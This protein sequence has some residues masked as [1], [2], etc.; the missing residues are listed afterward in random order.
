MAGQAGYKALI[1]VGGTPVPVTDEACAMTSPKNY[2]VTDATRRAV[3][4][5]DS[6]TVK[7]DASP[8]DSSLYFIDYLFGIVILDGSVA[9]GVMT[10]D[11][12]YVPTVVAAGTNSFS[13]DLGGDVLDTTQFREST[14]PQHGFRTRINGLND[15]SASMESIDLT[16]KTFVNAKLARNAVM[17]EFDFDG[18]GTDLAR[19]WFIVETDNTSLEVAGLVGE[20]ISLQLEADDDAMALRSFSF[21]SE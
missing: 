9:D 17:V 18:T 8:V 15:V 6:V 2:I 3:E 5:Y 21:Y 12:S 13:L 4:R 7:V 20:S 16:N 1:K 11:Y 19:G 10:I 14:D